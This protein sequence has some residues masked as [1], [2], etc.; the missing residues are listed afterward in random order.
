MKASNFHLK[1]LLL[2]IFFLFLIQSVLSQTPPPDLNGEALRTWLKQNYYDG[3]HT[4]LGYD[5]ARMR[6]Y[7]YIDNHNNTITGVYSGFQV[8]WTYGGT[9]TNPTPINCEHTVPQSFFN[10]DEPMKSDIHHL[11]PSYLNWNS[12]RSN[13]PFADIDDNVT[14]KWMYLD[15]SQTTIPTNN[16]D[17]YS[18]YANSTFEPRE[19]HKGNLARGIFYFY[20]M[21]PTQAGDIS[22]VA[23]IN[24]LYQWHMDDPVDASEISRNDAIQTYQGD[25]NPYIDQPDLVARAWDLTPVT[26]PSAPTLQLNATV[27]SLDLNWNDVTVEDGYKLYRSDNGVSYFLMVDLVANVTGYQDNNVSTGITYYYYIIAYNGEGNSDNSNVVSGQLQSGS[28]IAADLILS[29][30]VE[31]SSYNKAIEIANFTGDVVDLTNYSIMKQTNGAGDWASELSLSGTLADG[32]VY[33]IVN[34]QADSELASLADMLTGSHALTFNGNDPV[35]LFKNSQLIDVLGTFNN[36]KNY[37]KDITL[38]RNSSVNTPNTTYTVAEWDTYAQNTF[39]NLGSHTMNGGA[40]VD[41]EAPSI[42]NGL[43]SSDVTETTFTLSWNASTDNV[44]VTAY[45]VY[46]DGSWIGSSANTSY[47]ISGLSAWTTYSMTVKAK[48]AAGNVSAASSALNVTTADTHAPSVPDGLIASN[49]TETTFTLEW[50]TST[51]N[52]SVSGYDIYQNGSFIGSSSTISYS[53]TGLSAETTYS[54]T[55]KAKDAAGNTSSASTILNVTTDDTPSGLASDLIISEYIEGSSYNKALEIANFTGAAVDLANYSIMKQTNGAGSWASEL[56]LSGTLADG[57]VY[58]IV[59]SQAGSTLSSAADLITGSQALTFNGNDPVGLFKNS[60]LID[61]LG[62]FNSSAIFAQDVTLVRK[63]TVTSP[64]STYNINEWDSYGQN[65]FSY[66]GSHT[67]GGGS[68]PTDPVVLVNTDFE[69]GFDIWTDGGGDCALYTRSTYASQGSKAANIQDNSSTSSSFY[70]TNGIDIHTPDYTELT[71]EFSFMSISMETGE[72]FF[73]EYYDGSVWNIIASF[74]RGTDFENNIFYAVTVPIYETDYNFPTDMNLRFR[75]DASD[76][77]DDIYIDEIKVIATTGSTLKI[78][79]IASGYSLKS[80]NR[81]VTPAI[82]D[83]E[84]DMKLYP[85][86]AVTSATLEVLFEEDIGDIQIQVVDLQGR[87]VFSDKRTVLNNFM[88]LDLNV[89]DYKNGIYM[90]I[91]N[92][93]HFNYSKKLIV[94]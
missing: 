88:Q 91:I 65:T 66:I 72:N 51:D 37:A 35:G 50:N 80:L 59:N 63:S 42:P 14:I 61:I 6:M 24:T 22:S 34:S 27:S 49:I 19:D 43:G 39:T 13:H 90:V 25:R 86:P 52:V 10:Y 89:S 11:F 71:I 1:L 47:N 40:I 30:Y 78:A 44:A 45:D 8:S 38:V 62:T 12:T 32:E 77:K 15:Q 57:E 76:N 54:M 46:Q 2:P 18:E 5:N 64:A 79:S 84:L 60:I 21:Y 92:S 20:T 70:L 7:N 9:G 41:T 16:I 4:Q 81:S 68:S 26:V 82:E 58:V 23:D 69:S 48:D 3:N 17:L 93:S 73:F 36:K 94:R 33:V 74:S 53:I 85:I 75:C 31:G 29:E 67:M 56:T 87:V 83:L 28:G 55:V